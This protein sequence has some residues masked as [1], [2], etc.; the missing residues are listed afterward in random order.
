MRRATEVFSSFSSCVNLSNAIDFADFNASCVF[1]KRS[2]QIAA[3]C[4]SETNL[5]QSASLLSTWEARSDSL[6]SSL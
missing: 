2:L 4:E 6:S 1:S 3:C 5:C